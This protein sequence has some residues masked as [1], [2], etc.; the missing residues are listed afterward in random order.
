MVD[1]IILFL[2]LFFSIPNICWLKGPILIIY[3]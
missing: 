2:L 3:P 1:F